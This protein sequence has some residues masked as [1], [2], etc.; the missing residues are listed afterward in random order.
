[1]HVFSGNT[2]RNADYV[3]ILK[4]VESLAEP[5]DLSQSRFTGVT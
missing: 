3:H 4:R 1:M 5:S 2:V